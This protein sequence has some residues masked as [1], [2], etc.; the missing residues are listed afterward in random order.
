MYLE[1]I[2][3]PIDVKKLNTSELNVLCSEIRQQLIDTV[4]KNGGH[5][6]SNLGIVELTVGLHYVFNSP[7]D[8]IVF[9]VG[10]QS[11]VHKMLTG[12]LDNFS[13]IRKEDGLSG[14]MNPLESEHD[15][16]ITGHSSNSISI[17]SGIA[18]AN[19]LLGNKN[20]SI[21]VVGDG[22]LTG[23]MTFEA[24]NSSGQGKD[25]LIVILNDNKM[26]ISKNVGSLSKH[27]LRIRIGERYIR[28]K[29]KIRTGFNKIPLIGKPIEA[30]VGNVKT[31]FKNA[32]L[33]SNYFESLGYYYLG[34]IDGNNVEDV[35]MALNSAK[36][37]TRPVLIHACTV[38]GKGFAFAEK[39]PTSY[40]GVS[41]FDSDLGF[42]AS[43]NSF[44]SEMGKELVNI[45]TAND[46]VCAVTAAMTEGTGLVEFKK[47]LKNRFFDVGI[48][49]E[50][51]ITFCCGL[52]SKG[53]R[54]VFAV[55]SSFLQRGYDQLIHDA[56]ITSQNLTLCVDRAGI[57][58]EDGV[59]HQGLFDVAFLNTIPNVKVYSPAYFDE[60][61]AMLNSAVAE[62]GVSVVRYPRGKESAKPDNYTYN[63]E[64]Y[65]VYG[66]SDNIVVTYGRLFTNVY[67]AA[68]KANAACCKINVI[69]PMPNSLISDLMK[70]K[71]IY[72]VEE[73]IKSGGLGEHIGFKLME[74]GYKGKFN[75]RAVND[76]FI[77][78]MSTESAFKKLGF[79]E[80]SI[81]D[82]IKGSN[83]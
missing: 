13:T 14:F 50:H 76:E 81:V 45:A 31:A 12:R 49:E 54:P 16:A 21:A 79:D 64:E 28:L 27:L 78:H 70:Y 68:M 65:S 15:P 52:A 44:S 18:D 60:L 4:S 29:G 19:I 25:R 75:L 80:E 56:A 37:I 41:S 74:A 61:K 9:D 38:K 55:Y 23:G 2:K 59:T 5:L 77:A 36:T 72:V 82:F 46:K 83:N 67:N 42:E 51:A 10:H 20:Y 33:K 35:I 22:A 58:G 47:A 3:S 34:P 11:Y 71:N 43:G 66:S 40:H 57:V 32:L 1:N 48:A 7:D 26:S 30:F 39:S 69:K 24:L 17:A 63:G 8:S 73:G 6:A 53:L 62:D